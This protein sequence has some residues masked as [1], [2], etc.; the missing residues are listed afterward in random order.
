MYDKCERCMHFYEDQ[1]EY[2]YCHVC[3]MEHDCFKEISQFD[4][5]SR[6]MY[7]DRFND[8]Y[9]LEINEYAPP[10]RYVLVYCGTDGMYCESWNV[11]H[12]KDICLQIAFKEEFYFDHDYHSAMVKHICEQNHCVLSSLRYVAIPKHKFDEYAQRFGLNV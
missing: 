11:N 6:H 3:D 8:S 5:A 1:S 10:E 4:Q 2:H 9:T 12:R 7:W